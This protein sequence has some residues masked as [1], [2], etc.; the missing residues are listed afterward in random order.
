MFDNFTL[1]GL[2]R[3]SPQLTEKQKEDFFPKVFERARIEIEA[4]RIIR[5]ACEQLREIDR[6][7]GR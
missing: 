2:Y 1:E 6:R 3:L 4:Q 5:I 7:A